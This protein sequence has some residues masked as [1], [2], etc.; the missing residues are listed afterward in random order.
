MNI[1]IFEDELFNFRLLQHMLHE[2]N[3]DYI[4][5]GPIST[6]EE[7]RLYLST[8]ND[9][10]LIIADIQLND[11]LS[12]DALRNAPDDVP[13]IFTTAYEE[14]ALKAFEFNS[15]SYLLKPIDEEELRIAIKKAKRLIRPHEKE[16]LD[17]ISEESVY[18][19]R[20]VTK[21]AKG[22]K[23]ILVANVRYI[24]SEQKTTY[25]HL[26]D[27]SSF[28]IDMTIET[29]ARQ[30]NP[31]KFKQ[32]NRKYIIPIEQISATERLA[33][34]RLR[35]SLREDDIPDIFVSRTRRNEVLEW[36]DS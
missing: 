33:N 15:L 29:V 25:I 17:K 34:G 26:L 2:L 24:A 13:I 11:G 4:A 19:E 5:I 30:M 10:D 35:L 8:H 32:V 21:M 23:V 18:R 22:D 3:E 9:T 31:K 36:L 27:G 1:L 28:P 6:V 14:H 7:G 12:F 16:V 20:F